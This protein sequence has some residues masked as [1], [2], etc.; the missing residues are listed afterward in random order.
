MKRL[1]LTAPAL[2][3]YAG[4]IVASVSYA[5]NIQFDASTSNDFNVATNW[6][7][8]M[9]PTA[10]GDVHIV[11]NGLTAEFTTGTTTINGLIVGDASVGTFNMSGGTLNINVTGSF[12]QGFSLGG[13]TA[14]HT[15]LGTVN[16]TG[17]TI[18][19]NSAGGSPDTG[20]VGERADGVL[21]IGRPARLNADTI[22]WR[23]GQ[24]GGFF[25]GPPEFTGSGVIN[26]EG[27]M[28][29]RLMFLAPNG[30]DSEVTVSGSGSIYL[31]EALHSSV[32]T[33]R[34]ERSSIMRMVGSEALW[35]S[36]DIIANSQNG[37]VRN[38]FIF[39]ADQFGV[40]PMN[41]RDAI[42]YNNAELTVDLTSF[43]ELP[44]GQRMRLFDARPGQLANLTDG[45][46]HRFGVLNMLG[47]SDP[48]TYGL[49]YD[50]V[51]TGD[52]L[53][54]RIPEPSSLAVLALGGL[55]AVVGARRR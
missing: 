13:H 27:S 50:D 5:A 38:H 47:V 36:D 9:A 10:D 31:T 16:L 14:N 43:G 44:F 8:D 25:G 24:F 3:L 12:P 18:N 17:G 48:S 21:N 54:T 11:E 41:A 39:V 28:T 19:I 23:I 34:I 46:V 29:G 7:D 51:P 30:G 26:V 52:I 6:A 37:E 55:A 49:I 40:S 15:G 1:L 35:S 22:V 20:F 32:E 53:L 45:S 33:H 42:L 2:A 4:W